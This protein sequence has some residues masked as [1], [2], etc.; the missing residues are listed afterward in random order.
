MGK[1]YINVSTYYYP[2]LVVCESKYK[3]GVEK[4]V[5]LD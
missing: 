3:R 5:G 1:I 2:R 4:C